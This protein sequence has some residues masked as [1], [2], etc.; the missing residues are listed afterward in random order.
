MKTQTT[1]CSRACE[2]WTFFHHGFD[3]HTYTIFPTFG[4]RV[5]VVLKNPLSTPLLV[6]AFER[7][8]MLSLSA[9]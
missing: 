1:C 2:V 7:G 5:I 3:S 8:G 6:G 4:S 9:M